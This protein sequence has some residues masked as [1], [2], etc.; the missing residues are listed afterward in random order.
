MNTGDFKP[1]PTSPLPLGG[2]GVRV[3]E[4]ALNL[5][6]YDVQNTLHLVN[7]LQIVKPQ[8]SDFQTL[9]RLRRS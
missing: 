5:Q 4:P 7:H 3:L 8:H 6:K 1:T 9:Y 2:L